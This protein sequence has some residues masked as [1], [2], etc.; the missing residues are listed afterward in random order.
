MSYRFGSAAVA[1]Q[2][3]LLLDYRAISGKVR[4]ITNGRAAD[5]LVAER[6]L[7]QPDGELL[8]VLPLPEEKYIRDFA[9][10]ASKREFEVILNR[11]KQVRVLPPARTR[12][13]A[14]LA[15]GEY[16]L[17][18]CNGLLAVWDGY[19][20]QWQG[21]TGEVVNLARKSRKPLAWIHAGIG[22]E[23]TH[24]PTS[25]NQEQGNVSFENFPDG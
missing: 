10:D 22:I 23:G 1:G 7:Q 6:I 3:G 2:A 9:S 19:E 16:V 14:Y 21:G 5:R 15:A 13:L 11:T 25:L 4:P 17:D 18:H 24:Q 12:E 20:T 8:A